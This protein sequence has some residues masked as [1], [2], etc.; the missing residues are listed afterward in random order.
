MFQ[1][2]DRIN[3]N[4]RHEKRKILEEDKIRQFVEQIDLTEAG[5]ASCKIIQWVFAFLRVIEQLI[6]TIVC[7]V[8]LLLCRIYRFI[9][10]VPVF[11]YYVFM[12]N[13]VVAFGLFLPFIAAGACCVCAVL[14]WYMIKRKISL[15]TFI[16]T[17]VLWKPGV[18]VPKFGCFMCCWGSQCCVRRSF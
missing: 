6:G 2:N 11:V 17:L 18:I 10:N 3:A 15:Q 8:I 4:F 12:R 5:H 13:T 14:H 16:I 7:V 1:P 9:V